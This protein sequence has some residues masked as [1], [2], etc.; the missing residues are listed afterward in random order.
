MVLVKRP[1]PSSKTTIIITVH[2]AVLHR[3]EPI[4]HPAV[5]L[6]AAVHPAAAVHRRAARVVAAYRGREEINF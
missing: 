2:Q 1:G 3:A 4:Q 6:P 5:V